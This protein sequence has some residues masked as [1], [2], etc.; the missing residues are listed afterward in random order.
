MAQTLRGTSAGSRDAAEHGRHHVA[1]FQR[2]HNPLALLGIVAQPVQQ[3]GEAPLGGVDA[4]APVDGREAARVRG[5]GDF[6]RPLSR[7][8]GRTTGSSRRCGSSRSPTG[9][10]LEPVVS[11]AMASIACPSTP[12]LASAVRASPAPARS[13]GRRGSAWRDPDLP[14]C[15]AADTRPRPRPACPWRYRRSKPER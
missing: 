7:R 1:V 12:A 15:A 9:M 13:C 11:S 2:G 5:G 6:A 10:T 4:A 8:G 3:L 14:S